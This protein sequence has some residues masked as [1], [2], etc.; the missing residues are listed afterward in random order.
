M[1]LFIA[2]SQLFNFHVSDW[3]Q[4]RRRYNVT[5]QFQIDILA[6][7]LNH[8]NEKKP[9]NQL[10]CCNGMGPN[11]IY[12]ANQILLC[13]AI[14]VPSGDSLNSVPCNVLTFFVWGFWV[15]T[16]K[17]LSVTGHFLG[18]YDDLRRCGTSSFLLSVCK[19]SNQTLKN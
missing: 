5:V 11:K 3:W 12:K 8:Y 1:Y 19:R 16:S 15:D 4:R 9:H 17:F 14:I 6:F 10:S 2:L 13:W 18:L 7:H